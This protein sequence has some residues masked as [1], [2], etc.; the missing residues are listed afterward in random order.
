MPNLFWGMNHLYDNLL[1]A[2][3]IDTT[4]SDPDVGELFEI[5]VLPLDV[6]INPHVHLPLFNM[7]MRIHDVN[8][9]DNKHMMASRK[10]LAY[11]QINGETNDKVADMFVQWFKDLR[12]IYNR[13]IIPLTFNYYH[14]MR[15]L[16]NWLTFD[17]YNDIFHR[18]VRDI[19]I[20]SNFI[21]DVF[22]SR[23]MRH[24]FS[25][26]KYDFSQLCYTLKVKML[27]EKGSPTTNCLAISECY[28]AMLQLV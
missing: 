9:V 2:V 14:P 20:A 8:Y 15:F 22:G 10:E 25:L 16:I 3:C 12:L 17:V 19:K 7:R 27:N 24:P 1:A 5:C 13:R 23:M 4:Q 11:V 26:D 21:N 18:D 6:N 28:K